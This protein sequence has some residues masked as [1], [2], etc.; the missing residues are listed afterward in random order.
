MMAS[1]N[2]YNKCNLVPNDIQE[3]SLFWEFRCDDIADSLIY[4]VIC[5]SIFAVV[6]VYNYFNEPE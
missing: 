1:T 4:L 5:C 2:N 3:R 6:S